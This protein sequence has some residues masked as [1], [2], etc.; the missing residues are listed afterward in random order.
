M[1]GQWGGQGG[2]CSPDRGLGS[3]HGV[4][5]TTGVALRE[6]SQSIPIELLGPA[7]VSAPEPLV[8]PAG[9]LLPHIGG[10]GPPPP[11]PPPTGFLLPHMGGGGPLL[12]PGSPPGGL[13]FAHIGGGGPPA[14]GSVLDS[15]PG[16]LRFAHIGG[17]GLPAVGSVLGSSRMGDSGLSLPS[18]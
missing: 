1:A 10:G 16:G 17:G 12:P 18:P 14:A 6:D 3:H 7:S 4:W 2:S 5:R 15:P 13:R 8:D 11:P 9:F